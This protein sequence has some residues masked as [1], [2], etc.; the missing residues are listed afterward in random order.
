[1][2]I[3]DRDFFQPGWREIVD[4]ITEHKPSS[5]NFIHAIHF[6]KLSDFFSARENDI[7]TKSN[8][9]FLDIKI[10][11]QETKYMMRE[12]KNHLLALIMPT[13]QIYLSIGGSY[14]YQIDYYKD[15]IYKLNL[16]YEFWAHK[17]PIKLK[18]EQPTLG[19]YDPL[20]D[21]SQL[22]ATWSRSPLHETQTIYERIPKKTKSETTS[23][24][25]EQ[26]ELFVNRYPNKSILFKQNITILQQGGRWIK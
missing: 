24:A 23:A 7:I 17:I 22:I 13:S 3:Y 10:P 19:C 11:L 15:F 1:M 18:Y 5:I 8:D 9:V 20:S 14:Q 16:L 12:Y 4:D 6:Y 2:Y 25:K 26:L 21:L